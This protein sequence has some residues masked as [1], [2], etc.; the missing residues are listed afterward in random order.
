MKLRIVSPALILTLLFGN[1]PCFASSLKSA[2]STATTFETLE[3]AQSVW[4]RFTSPGGDFTILMPGEPKATA[5]STTI[6][7]A[8]VAIVGYF[9]ERY[10][11]TVRYLV[12]RIDFPNSLD[13]SKI[14]REQFLS[15]MQNQIL[16]Q[17][18]GEML[19]DRVVMLGSYPGREIK[20]QTTSNNRPYIAINRLYWVDRSIYQISVTVPQ[21]L[22][23]SL[24]GSSTGFL[25]SFKL[26][27]IEPPANPIEPPAN[28]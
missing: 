24:A 1:A 7:D 20:L 17:T 16:Q 15:A 4:R 27:P 6:N 3:I 22:E 26:I 9:V 18:N 11:D 28:S 23:S 14:D 13:T 8:P 2:P 10:D 19:Q 12:T 25:D 5:A 21:N